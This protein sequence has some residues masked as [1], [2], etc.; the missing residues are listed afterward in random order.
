MVIVEYYLVRQVI[1]RQNIDPILH[2]D[3]S[4]NG[5]FLQNKNLSL[6]NCH[7]EA[8]GSAI[9]IILGFNMQVNDIFKFCKIV[10]FL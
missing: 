10:L 4:F 9:I 6:Y 5:V 2:W 8:K 7:I 3:I 1:P